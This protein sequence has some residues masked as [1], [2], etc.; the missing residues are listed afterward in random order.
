MR[1][2]NGV[3]NGIG[4]VQG[5]IGFGLRDGIVHHPGTGLNSSRTAVH[6]GGANDNAGIHGAV[7]AQVPHCP[8][9]GAAADAFVLAEELGGPQLRGAGQRAHIHRRA[10][11]VECVEVGGTITGEHGVGVEKRELMTTQFNAGDMEAQMRV[12]DVFDPHWLL[13]AA[14]VFPL[15][16]SAPRREAIRNAA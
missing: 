8:A 10:V 9:V 13:N 6:E 14:K 12:K 16:V 15:A 2:G 11:G 4:L 7:A 5:F 1:E 3:E